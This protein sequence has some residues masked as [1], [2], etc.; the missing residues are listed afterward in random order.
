MTTSTT[1]E[2]DN[3]ILVRNSSQMLICSHG[4]HRC[5]TAKEQETC[6]IL[7]ELSVPLPNRDRLGLFRHR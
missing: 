3:P 5:L 1:T 6:T 4:N 7:G 2:F